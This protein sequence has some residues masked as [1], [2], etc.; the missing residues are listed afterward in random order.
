MRLTKKQQN[1]LLL[2]LYVARAGRCK[3]SDAAE[4]LGVSY[5]FL[6]QIA[7]KLRKRGLLASFRGPGGGFE[8]F[9]DPTAGDVIWC[10]GSRPT[11]NH[12]SSGSSERRALGQ[13]LVNANIAMIPVLNCKIRALNW[14][15]ATRESAVITGMSEAAVN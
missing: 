2:A 8:L 11:N 12:V 10:L 7:R 14:E 6:A 4:E 3:V 1:G 15:L 13:L 9:G 5:C